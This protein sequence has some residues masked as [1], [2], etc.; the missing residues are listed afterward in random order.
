MA[1]IKGFVISGLAAGGVFA[2]AVGT[3]VVK[4]E[5][6]ATAKACNE[7]AR[8]TEIDFRQREGFNITDGKRREFLRIEIRRQSCIEKS[9]QPFQ[10]SVLG[11]TL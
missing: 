9:E 2:A 6:P 7:T 5:K 4:F 1:D 8:L 3:D 10:V 11:V